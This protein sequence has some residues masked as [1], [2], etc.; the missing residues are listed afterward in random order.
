MI[1]EKQYEVRMEDI[2][3]NNEL[4]NQALLGIL[5]DVA[6]HHSDMV[7]LRIIRYS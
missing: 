5:E 1:I 6:C 4:T 2:G 3:K 7:G